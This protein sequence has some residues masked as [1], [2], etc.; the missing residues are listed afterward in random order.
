MKLENCKVF[1]QENITSE[2]SETDL[3]PEQLEMLQR[4]FA[5][6]LVEKTFADEMFENLI[7]EYRKKNLANRTNALISVLRDRLEY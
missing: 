4:E 3:T 1:R 2:E 6:N 7:D 5:E